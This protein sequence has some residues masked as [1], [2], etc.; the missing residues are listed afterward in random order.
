MAKERT[1]VK[2][3]ALKDVRAQLSQFVDEAQKS[4]VV[5]N[6]HGKPAAVIVGVEGKTI[7]QVMEEFAPTKK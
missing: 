3:V 6:K 4:V 1:H 5:I 7:E 2:F